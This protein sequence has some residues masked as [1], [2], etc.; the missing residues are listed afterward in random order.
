MDWHNFK[1]LSMYGVIVCVILLIAGQVGFAILALVGYS[2]FGVASTLKYNNASLSEAV[3]SLSAKKDEKKHGERKEV[4][5]EPGKVKIAAKETP[6]EVKTEVKTTIGRRGCLYPK[7]I[8]NEKRIDVLT[9]GELRKIVVEQVS[10]RHRFVLFLGCWFLIGS[11]FSIG[12][13]F[14]GF[15]SLASGTSGVAFGLVGAGLVWGYIEM[16][17]KRKELEESVPEIIYLKIMTC[18]GKE[19]WEGYESDD[20]ILLTDYAPCCVHDRE[21]RRISVGDKIAFVKIENKMIAFWLKEWKI[22]GL[23]QCYDI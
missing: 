4:S 9:Q 12:L 14:F 3:K 17:K 2:A 1:V 16:Q 18:T 13:S 21:Y 22:E 5:R 10:K 11:L 23:N 8:E 20:Q 15:A 19:I 7:F 6:E